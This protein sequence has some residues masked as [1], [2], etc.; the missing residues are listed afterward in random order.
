VGIDTPNS[1]NEFAQ[2]FL[3][4]SLGGEISRF[5]SDAILTKL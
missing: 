3:K 1:A 5:L 4:V 2:K